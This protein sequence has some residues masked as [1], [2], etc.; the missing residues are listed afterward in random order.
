MLNLKP[1][2]YKQLIF[3]CALCVLIQLV[4][5]PSLKALES[6]DVSNVKALTTKASIQGETFNFELAGQENWDYEVK[7]ISDK[8]YTKVQLYVKA[9][10][11]Q[12]VNSNFF[13]KINRIDNPYVD[14]V[15]VAKEKIDGKIL[16]EFFLKSPEVES[17]DYLTDQPSKLI[18]DFYQKEDQGHENLVGNGNDNENK[19]KAKDSNT[20]LSNADAD[21]QTKSNKIN[22]GTL[23]K[24][25]KEAKLAKQKN[26]KPAGLD[27]IKIDEPGGI[28]ASVLSKAG[29]FDGG[30]ADYNRFQLLNSDF[31]DDA[32]IKSQFNYYLKFPQID[33]D[34][35]FWT[36]MKENPP[37]YEIAEKNEK[38][39]KEARL[40][41][42]LFLKKRYLVF[43]KTVDWFK[44]KYPFSQY[45]EA[46]LYM[47]AEVD[48]ETWKTEKN[49]AN[50]NQAQYLYKQ[51]LLKYPESPLAERTSLMT[52]ML[53][54]DKQD[55]MSAIRNLTTHAENKKYSEKISACY[56]KL[57]IAFSYSKLNRLN[58][59][60]GIISDIEK[61][62]KDPLV[63]A[64]AAVSKGDFYFHA[65][66]HED[67]IKFYNLAIKNHEIVS[68][69]FPGAY[70]NKMESQFWLKKYVDAH[71]SALNFSRSFSEHPYVPYALTRVGELLDILGADQLKSV[72]AF[73]ETHFRFGDNP[74]T[75]VAR[76]HL[77]STRMKSMKPEELNLTLK[78]M[79]ELSEKSDLENIDQFT[80]AMTSDGFS[81]RKDYLKS[82]EILSKFYQENPTRADA[83]QVT[84]RI[85]KNL[86]DQLYDLAEEK[87]F[88]KLLQTHQMYSDTWLHHQNRID[89]DYMLGLSYENAGDYDTAIE[90]FSSTMEKLSRI[91]NT[92]QEK[93]IR[94]KEHLPTIDSLQLKIAENL[95]E[96]KK[97]QDSY[98]GLEKIKFPLKLTEEDQIKRIILASKL[99]EQ[100]GDAETAIR[101]LSEMSR[102]WKGSLDVE[103]PA[104][105]RLGEM[106]N[107]YNNPAISM[108]T[109]KNCRE[110]ILK[111]ERPDL[112][113]L[114]RISRNFVEI[115]A[116]Q[117][118]SDEAIQFL[119]GLVKKF[120]SQLNLSEE[121]YELGQLYFAK[122]EIKKA[123]LAWESIPEDKNEIWKKLANE[124]LQQANWDSSY[125][126][127]IKRIPAMSQM[128]EFK[129]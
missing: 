46:I 119:E 116:Q 123:S 112:L 88:K 67:A 27:F 19:K 1:Y 34:F 9:S 16:V 54:V 115:S 48:I 47:S 26:R 73:L 76:L 2:F 32:V 56:A 121:K 108:E 64:S 86:N 100:K 22:S 10:G 42:T 18:I 72:G 25:T 97:F 24:G 51:I 13:E 117:K 74:K 15:K 39:N 124:K 109:F 111:Q 71:A 85:L 118:K 95:F 12:T 92:P 31:K 30:D 41:K 55:Y 60:L 23:K 122:G 87:N 53:S 91:T 58:E 83:M 125:K 102:L 8:K 40:I 65:Q 126:K 29:L 7:R 3:K 94:I 45:L 33:A 36:K 57:G 44:T 77:L 28:E 63:L 37:E 52:G 17:F 66:K 81:R 113:Q 61:T 11:D 14:K 89:T 5:C 106:Q 75:I 104:L 70:F 21:I 62:C 68:K 114:R 69:L 78:K 128:E 101:Y 43:K 59:A 120:D 107:K 129:K 4:F 84:S 50:Y 105:I 80:I 79:K 110:I 127:H 35:I 6:L 38:E 96:N 82:I 98:K 20:Q 93:E 49:D 99:Y 90:K 103:L